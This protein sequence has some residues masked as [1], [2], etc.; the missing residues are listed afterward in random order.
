MTTPVP[1]KNYSTVLSVAG[2]SIGTSGSPATSS[3]VSTGNV[4][5]SELYINYTQSALT[6]LQVLVEVS[7]DGT[8]WYSKSLLDIGN[9]S[10]VSGKYTIPFYPAVYQLSASG[11]VVVDLPI[12]HQYLRVKTWGTGSANSGDILVVGIGG[13]AV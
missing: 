6:A 12:S 3:A 13:G 7:Q 10:V 4:N 1:A 11:T 5:Q 9:G 2:A 8:T